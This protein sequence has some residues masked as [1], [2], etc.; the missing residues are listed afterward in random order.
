MPI[1]PADLCTV[2]DLKT[3]LNVQGSTDDALFQRLV[4]A[5]SVYM[6]NWMNRTIH[7][8]SYTDTRDGCGTDIIVLGNRPV[9]EV[10]SLSVGGVSVA[11]SLDGVQAGFVFDDMAVYLVGSKFPRG[12]QNVKISYKAGWATV[13]FDLAQAAIELAAYRYRE[14]GHIGQTG[15][16]MGPEHISYSER[17][18]PPSV[19]TLMNQYKSVVV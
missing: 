7:S 2:D 3:W 17:D 19:K 4:T 8:M 6:Q 12:R 16:G 15:T 1:N 18:L 10:T 13:P 9:T 14:K 5:V 11:P